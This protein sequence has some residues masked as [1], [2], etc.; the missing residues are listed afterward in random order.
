[1]IGGQASNQAFSS[2]LKGHKLSYYDSA[3][4]ATTHTY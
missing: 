1:M 3:A 4:K 2:S